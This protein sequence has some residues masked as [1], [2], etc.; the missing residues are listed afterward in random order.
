MNEQHENKEDTSVQ[1]DNDCLE[2]TEQDMECIMIR[3]HVNCV[4]HTLQLVV[5]DGL[6]QVKPFHSVIATA[7][8]LVAHVRKSTYA[9]EL[10]ADSNHLQ[11]AKDKWYQVEQSAKDVLFYYTCIIW[12]KLNNWIN[13]ISTAS[14]VHMKFTWSRISVKYSCHVKRPQTEPK[15]TIL[16]PSARSSYLPM[17][18]ARNLLLPVKCTPANFVKAL[19]V[20]LKSD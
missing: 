17:V 6:K 10:F 5:W 11:M 19:Q 3:E 14:W 12:I 16:S 8:R 18:F 2:N 7:S 13:W 1:E 9:T 4:A 15:V 20:V